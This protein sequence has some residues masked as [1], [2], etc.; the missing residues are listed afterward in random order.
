MSRIKLVL[1]A[2]AVVLVVS[3]V[4]SASAMAVTPKYFVEGKEVTGAEK[5][6]FT[7]SVGIARLNTVVG[8][9]KMVIECTANKLAGENLFEAEGKSKG[10]FNLESCTLYEVIKSGALEN[11]SEK[12]LVKTPVNLKY[13]AQLILGPG[14]LSENEFKPSTGEIFAEVVVESAPGKTCLIAAD[15]QAKGSYAATTGPESEV[16][17]KE[18]ESVFTSGG[19]KLKIGALPASFT[20]KVSGLKLKKAV[21]ETT[22]KKFRI[23]TEE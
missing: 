8:G 4:A 2:L 18:H 16:E 21:T 22:S 3:V 9:L 13:A 1:P 19:S 7:G 6:A 17:K 14:G 23:F 15:L 12:C 5:Y 20:D 10:E 11:K